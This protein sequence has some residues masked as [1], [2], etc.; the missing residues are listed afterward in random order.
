MR[1]MDKSYFELLKYRTR[2]FYNEQ[3]YIQ[4]YFCKL[5]NGCMNQIFKFGNTFS[6]EEENALSN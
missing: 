5:G 2:G 1:E 3:K 4:I 6:E